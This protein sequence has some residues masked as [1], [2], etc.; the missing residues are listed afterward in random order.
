[1]D[2]ILQC[3]AYYKTDYDATAMVLKE[4]YY[5]RSSHDF[6]AAYNVQVLVASG[7]IMIY[8]IFQDRADYYTLIPMNNN[9]LA[10][11]RNYLR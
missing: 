1:M 3:L 8:G 9:L 5:S 7:L 4:D 2:I 10:K 6:H 11:D